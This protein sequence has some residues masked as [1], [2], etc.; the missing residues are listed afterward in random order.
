M[1]ICKGHGLKNGL[2]VGFFSFSLQI[3]L[4]EVF[5]LMDK[6]KNSVDSILN[7]ERANPPGGLMNTFLFNF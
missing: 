5:F 1:A 3:L 7:F 2:D 4:F 6:F